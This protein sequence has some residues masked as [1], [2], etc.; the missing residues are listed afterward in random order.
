MQ[1]RTRG[2]FA[3]A[4]MIDVAL[5]G[6][7]RPVAMATI[8]RRQGISMSYL[9]ELFGQLKRPGLLVSVRGPGGGYR[10]GRPAEEI[11]VAEI[12]AAVDEP[13]D[14]AHAPA[15]VAAA[16]RLVLDALW[17]SLSDKVAE[18]LS[19]VSLKSLVDRQ[20]ASGMPVAT[21]AIRR[22]IPSPPADGAPAGRPPNSIFAFGDTLLPD[23]PAR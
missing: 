14:A 2:R 7:R 21:P 17:A 12:V 9:E 13:G 19:S 18:Y 3:V 6:T 15:P 5:H 1:V 22:V 8:S 10:L 20:L 16:G 23:V 4:A 11:S